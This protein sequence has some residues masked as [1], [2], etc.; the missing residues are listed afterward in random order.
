[1]KQFGDSLEGNSRLAYSSIHKIHLM[2]LTNATTLGALLA[3]VGGGTVAKRWQAKLRLD[4]PRPIQAM[5]SR[6]GRPW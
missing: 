2:N 6:G 3:Y 5:L 1:M 4:R